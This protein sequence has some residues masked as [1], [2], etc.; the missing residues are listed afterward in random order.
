MARA[1]VLLVGGQVL[2]PQGYERLAAQ[3]ADR[4]IRAY[5]V[6]EGAS[7]GLRIDGI[8][9]EDLW[10]RAAPVDDLLQREPLE[11]V[12]ASE[13]TEVRVLFDDDALYVAVLAYDS[14]PDRVVGRILQRDRL[15]EPDFFGGGLE[16]AG[17]DAVAVLLDPFHDHRSGVVFA[18]NPNGAEFDALISNEG[19]DINIDWRGVWEVAGAR[20]PEGW[21]AEFAIPWR[22]LRYPDAVDEPWGFNVFRVIRRKNEEVLWRAWER[23]GGGFQRVSAA[24]HLEGLE[25]LPRQGLNLESKPFVLGGARQELND[26][27]ALQSRNTLDA[28]LDVKTELRPGLVLDL[29]FNT[30]FAQVEVDDEQVNLTR[31]DL[32]FPEKRDFFLENSGIFQFGVPGNPFEPPPFQMFFSRQIGIDEDEGE[33]PILGG[34]RLTGRVGGQTVGLINI[35]TDDA[36]GLSRESFSAARVKRD[37]G[38]SNYV[39]V[40]ATDRRGGGAWNTVVGVDGQ[41]IV[42]GAWVWDWFYARTSSGGEGGDDHAYRVGLDYT[43]DEWGLFFNHLSVGPDAEA[44]SGFIVRTDVRRTDLFG[45]RRWRPT[46]LGLRRLDVW[47]GFNYISTMG[48][49][50]QDYAYGVAFNPEWESGDTFNLWAN[51]S[52]TILDEIFE[53]TDDVDVPLGR[54]RNDHVMLF[55]N[56]SKRRA[57]SADVNAMLSKF[58]GGTLKSAGGSLTLAPS[59][60]VVL[61][62]GFTRND[63]D[64]PTGSFTADITSLR[65]SYSFS[66][67]LTTNV[68]VQY[69]SLDRAFSTNVRVNFIHRPGSDLFIVF[70]E[71]RGDDRRVWNLQDRGLVM[72][73]TYLARL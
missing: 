47:S 25:G 61:G 18:T 32:F 26:A 27:E 43:G 38:E 24:G 41:T 58:Y 12:P 17:D 73:L 44:E 8:L 65:A 67:R 35:V 49:R 45:R 40:M 59:P 62:L 48:W 53:L 50:M 21:S 28:G 20:I 69:N 15:M 66:T 39:G 10:S 6:P 57:A 68:L 13:R 29:T 4:P 33:V 5:R 22:S 42:D 7:A 70:T 64:V 23:V 37:V 60:Q 51:V 14:E 34:A 2:A 52:E 36:H 11:G 72:K 30:D 1:L 71:N 55:G 19:G 16:F 54:Y 9:S 46:A 31:F 63:V 56:T 3:A